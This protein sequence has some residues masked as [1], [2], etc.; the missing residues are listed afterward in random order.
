MI[1]AGSLVL[2]LLL[3]LLYSCDAAKVVR[4]PWTTDG[5]DHA[6]SFGSGVYGPDGP[7]QAIWV[8]FADASQNYIDQALWPMDWP[9][10]II[11]GFRSGG[12]V[13]FGTLA[14]LDLENW[15]AD[16]GYG[17]SY[18]ASFEGRVMASAFN[19]SGLDDSVSYHVS[20]RVLDTI[21]W[22]VSLPDGRNYTPQVGGL[23]LRRQL[24][25]VRPTGEIYHNG[26]L[27]QLKVAGAIASEFFGLHMGR[28]WG[29]WAS[30]GGETAQMAM[31][32]LRDVTIGVETGSSPFNVSEI[33]SIYQGLQ[34]SIAADFNNGNGGRDDGAALVIP[35]PEVP[36]IYLPLGTCEAAASY[37][38]VTWDKKIRYYLWDTT[39]ANYTRIVNSPTYLGFILYDSTAKNITIKVPFKLLNLTLGPPIVD[40]PVPYFPCHPYNTTEG[41][42]AL[43][44]AFLQAAFLGVKYDQNLA[45]LAQAP[46]PDMDPSV[47]VQVQPNATTLTTNSIDTFEKTWRSY[48]ATKLNAEVIIGI[49]M[50]AAVG[51]ILAAEAGF[52]CWRRKRDGKHENNNKLDCSGGE[53]AP[54]VVVGGMGHA[55]PQ[56]MD[57]L[58]GMVYEIGQPLP[59]EMEWTPVPQELWGPSPVSEMPAQP[60]FSLDSDHMDDDKM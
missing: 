36:G 6:S 22:S 21:F 32:W 12:N 51:I 10:S 60:V 58:H 27:S 26:V 28:P 4:L 53:N 7:W 16:H 48:T 45:F 1:G 55:T 34:S 2:Q 59:H 41:F 49:A 11:D 46:G 24:D 50:G 18:N 9:H 43:G 39:N 38:P 15:A 47:I 35:S 44:R 30:S 3:A 17:S 57:G 5:P 20:N 42:W 19:L 25:D 8:S 33:G 23:G 13:S 14:P 40:K 52:L 54:E 37:L 29:Q 56:E 31:M